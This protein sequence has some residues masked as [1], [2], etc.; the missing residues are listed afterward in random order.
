MTDELSQLK[1]DLRRA[2]E[3][4]DQMFHAWKAMQMKAE[5]AEREARHLADLLALLALP[6]KP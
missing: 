1:D 4:C 2:R 3:R 5:A 6:T